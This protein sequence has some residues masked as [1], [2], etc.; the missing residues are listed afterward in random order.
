M[1]NERS[2]YSLVFLISRTR[3]KKNGECPVFLK[4]NING[5]KTRFAVQRHVL[6]DKWDSRGTRMKGRTKEAKVF[7]DYLEAI[8]LRANNLYNELLKMNAEVTPQMLKDAILG[9]NEARPKTIIAVFND[10]IERLHAL[11]GK[12]TTYANFQKYRTTRNHL[13]AYLQKAYRVSDVSIKRIDH[14]MIEGFEHFLKTEKGCSHNTAIKFLQ[15][16]KKIT[17]D[18]IKCGWLIRDPFLNKGLSLKEV[19]RPYLN[20]EELHRIMSLKLPFERLERVRDYFLFACFTGLSYA[21]VKKFTRKE[22]EITDS[23]KWIKNLPKENRRCGFRS[24]P[25]C[26]L[27][28]HSEVQSL[29]RSAYAGRSCATYHEQPEDERLPERNS[30]SSQNYQAVELP[31]RETH[32]CHHRNHA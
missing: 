4:I 5:D 25:R 23:G 14:R 13:Q 20:E 32:V 21:D 27:A 15:N 17:K 11:L 12:E 8:K 18:C 30:G 31:H 26:G 19:S 1:Y 22:I 29:F 24:D 3:P 10:Y 2:S 7:N 6:P 9:T 16:V 28:N